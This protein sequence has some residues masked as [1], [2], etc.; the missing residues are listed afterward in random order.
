MNDMEEDLRRVLGR[1]AE[2]APRA[3]GKLVSHVTA[4]SVRRRARRR[5]AVTGLAVAV[6]AGGVAIAVSDLRPGGEGHAAAV[7]ASATAGP[8][9]AQD[10]AGVRARLREQAGEGAFRGEEPMRDDPPP[11]PPLK[12]VEQVWPEAVR[13]V[14]AAPGGKDVHPRAFI[15]D[16]TLLVD[17][18]V[19]LEKPDAIYAYDLET[20]SLREIAKV[21]APEGTVL[22]ASD[23]AVG[24]GRVAWWSARRAGGGKTIDLWTAPLSG[25]A[26]EPLLS[27]PGRDLDHL[28]VAGDRLVFSREDGGVYTVPLAGG[29]LQPVRGAAGR[30]LLRW[31]WAG[32]GGRAPEGEEPTFTELWNAE[33]GEK[34]TALVKAGE[35]AV[36][37]GLATC[38]GEKPG[39]GYFYRMRD[40]SGEKALPHGTFPIT[41]EFARDRYYTAPFPAERGLGGAALYDAATGRAADL[42]VA[43]EDGGESVETPGFSPDGRLLAYPK[44]GELHVIDA[45]KLG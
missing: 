19:S 25:G 24:S 5:I 16:R 13:K 14:P 44:G 40:G 7:A 39:G 41:G 29:G 38:Y 15:D 30:H 6:I 22:F 9:A 45:D 8:E 27:F 11:S 34:R 20:A 3:P 12:P 23:Y 37:C 36:R 26:A 10:E 43:P 21:P 33:T 2:R 28:A 18:W 35:R 32:A 4:T 31:P 1:A 42:G 17:T